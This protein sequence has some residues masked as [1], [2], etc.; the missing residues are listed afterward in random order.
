VN[1]PE[2]SQPNVPA[3]WYPDPG[4]SGQQRYWDGNA[5]TEH[6]HA[7]AGA[8]PPPAVVPGQPVAVVAYREPKSTGLAIFLSIL[9]PG[10]G[11]LYAGVKTDFG[12]VFLVIT[13]VNI[14]LT[15]TLGIITLFG[16]CFGV[17]I[18]GGMAIWASIDVNATM[19][20]QEFYG[21]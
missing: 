18:W 12:T 1:E 21:A 19:K 11:H 13:I 5:W 2:D 10:A 4:G 3:G 15:L 6:F 7:A 17:L 14:V 8:T 9:F 20:Q 16:W